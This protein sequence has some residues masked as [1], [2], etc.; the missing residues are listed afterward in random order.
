MV[1]PPTTSVHPTV[2]V[3]N[4]GTV[5]EPVVQVTETLA[6]ADPPGAGPPPPAAAGGTARVRV[7]LRSGS[8]AALSMKP[9][10]VASGH[11]YTLTFAIA[12]PV[13][14]AANNP[15]GSTQQLVLQ[16]AG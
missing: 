2:T 5:V 6:L 16:I 13:S 15:A 11:R 12:L 1:M 8:S 7:S 3:T 14:Q 4:C 10:T 9:V